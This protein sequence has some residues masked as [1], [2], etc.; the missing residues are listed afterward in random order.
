[1]VLKFSLK[2]HLSMNGFTV[3]VIKTFRL[4][5]AFKKVVY[6]LF[7]RFFSPQSIVKK[8]TVQF[9]SL[10]VDSNALVPID[11]LIKELKEYG[12]EIAESLVCGQQKIFRSSI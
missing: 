10:D 4:C 2:R 3:Q 8:T 6:S 1:M 7:P 11:L 9:R 12:L 5:N